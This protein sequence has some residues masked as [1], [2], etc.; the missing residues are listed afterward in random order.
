[1]TF[2]EYLL[3]MGMSRSVYYA[4]HLVFALL[5]ALPATIAVSILIIIDQVI[6][7]FR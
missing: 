2:Q 3:V 1:M 6:R 7:T 4:H 5:K